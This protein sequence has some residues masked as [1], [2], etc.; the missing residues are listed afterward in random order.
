MNSTHRQIAGLQ[1]SMASK[2]SDHDPNIWPLRFNRVPMERTRRA[3]DEI[4]ELLTR[5]TGPAPSM[6][7]ANL[8]SDAR[9]PH[10]RKAQRQR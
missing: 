2:P 7:E 4:R 5:W 6:I 8:L 9:M 3:S 1:G 10:A